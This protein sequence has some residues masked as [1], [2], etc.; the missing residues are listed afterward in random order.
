MT[1]IEKI[2]VIGATGRLGAPVAKELAKS[3]EL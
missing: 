2:A 1:P 3:F